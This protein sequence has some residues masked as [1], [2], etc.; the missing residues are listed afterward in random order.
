MR[1]FIPTV[2]MPNPVAGHA[3]QSK[4]MEKLK[5]GMVPTKVVKQGTKVDRTISR[6]L[7]FRLCH[8]MKFSLPF[9]LDKL[10]SCNPSGDTGDN[11]RF[12]GLN[13]DGTPGEHATYQSIVFPEFGAAPGMVAELRHYGKKRIEAAPIIQP[14]QY[15]HSILVGRSNPAFA[16]LDQIILRA[17]IPEDIVVVNLDFSDEDVLKFI[18][19]FSQEIQPELSV[20][21]CPSFDKALFLPDDHSVSRPIGNLVLEQ[22]EFAGLLATS[23]RDDLIEEGPWKK[24]EQNLVLKADPTTPSPFLALSSVFF[25]E[26][27]DGKARFYSRKPDEV[28]SSFLEESQA[29]E[30]SS[31][32]TSKV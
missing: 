23:A 16:F 26:H 31:D 6:S 19:S 27:K 4:F 12:N 17:V 28:V 30:D 2:K 11:N 32:P 29:K 3:I 18:K 22:D 10:M 13:N 24:F 5:I 14:G 21:K 15:T 7:A 20:L 25:F 8:Q 9:S 1:R